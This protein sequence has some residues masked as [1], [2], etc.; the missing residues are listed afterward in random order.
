MM[1]GR[2]VVLRVTRTFHEPGDEILSVRDLVVK[3]ARGL[4]ALRGVSFGVRAG[5]IYGI[6]GIEGNGQS[7]LIEAIMGLRHIESGD[8]LLDGQSLKG[9]TPAEVLRAGL[10]HVPED[11]LRR[12][13]VSQF[14]VAENIVLGHHRTGAFAAMGMLRSSKIDAYAAKLIGT[15]DIRTPGPD[16]TMSHLS[17][18][19]Q[20][21]TVLARVLGSNPRA[22]VAS[23]PTRGVDVGAT[24]FIHN[25]LLEMRDRGAAILLLSADLDEV[26]SL[27]DRIGVICQ[28]RIVTEDAA[29]AFTEEELG[30]C[31]AGEGASEPATPEEERV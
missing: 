22:L 9:K 2:E 30:L 1:V 14:T 7:E 18:G 25:H 5:Q 6:A 29:E 16:T 12:G 15:Y 23:Q 20:Q 13:L 10:G 11:R 4:A 3:D 21:K 17:G 24:E 27:S 26:R 28:G 8:V 19:N 31:M